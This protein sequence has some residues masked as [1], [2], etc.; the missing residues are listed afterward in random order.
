MSIK[1]Q[2]IAVQIDSPTDT[3]IN[4]VLVE[5]IKVNKSVYIAKSRQR[6]YKTLDNILPNHA[7]KDVSMLNYRIIKTTNSSYYTRLF[8]IKFFLSYNLMKTDSLVFLH[9]PH[10]FWTVT[11]IKEA[12]NFQK[13]K[14]QL[15]GVRFCFFSQPGV[16]YKQVYSSIEVIIYFSLEYLWSHGKLPSTYLLNPIS[17]SGYLMISATWLINFQIVLFHMKLSSVYLVNFQQLRKLI[18]Q[19]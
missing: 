3:L 18:A 1:T 13:A 15:N 14:V 4:K 7:L 5:T 19:M 6:C 11:W 9:I 2:I 16:G 8:V 10:Y 12:N 17:A